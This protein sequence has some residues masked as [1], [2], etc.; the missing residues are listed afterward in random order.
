MFF[1]EKFHFLLAFWI[2]QNIFFFSIPNSHISYKNYVLDLNLSVL[3]L[4]RDSNTHRV[5]SGEG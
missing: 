3:L 5:R 2:C 4:G 1:L